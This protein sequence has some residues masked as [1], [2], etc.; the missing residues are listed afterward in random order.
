MFQCLSISILCLSLACNIFIIL[1]LKHNWWGRCHVLSL[2]Y[3]IFATTTTYIYV[4]IYIYMYIYKGLFPRLHWFVWLHNKQILLFSY[5]Y[6][7]QAFFSTWPSCEYRS[8]DKSKLSFGAKVVNIMMTTLPIFI[9]FYWLSC[10]M[11]NPKI[12]TIRWCVLQ[13]QPFTEPSKLPAVFTQ[14]VRSREATHVLRHHLD[15]LTFLPQG[16]GGG[17]VYWWHR[18]AWISVYPCASN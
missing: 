4:Y 11:N 12:W 16:F 18:W 5:T 2:W 17:G 13:Q 8:H 6:C 7:N 14:H 15:C 10:M 9:C 1:Y 3:V